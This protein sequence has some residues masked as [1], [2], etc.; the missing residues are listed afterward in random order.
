MVDYPKD[1]LAERAVLGSLMVAPRELF[2]VA[3]SY[4]L[5]E[6]DFFFREHRE[7]YRVVREL[8][9]EL[10][11]QWDDV[12]LFERIQKHGINLSR[13]YVLRIAEEGNAQEVLFVSA[14]K[15]IKELSIKRKLI[16]RVLV[17]FKDYEKKEI[18]DLAREVNLTL[19][20]LV[21]E[22][23]GGGVISSEA[24]EETIRRIKL[25]AH[26]E[27]VITGLPTGFMEL[28]LLTLGFHEGNYVVIG[29][30]P[31]M[32]KTSFMLCSA[33]AQAEQGHS[34]LI[35][36][37]EMSAPSLFERLLSVLS[38]VELSKIRSGFLNVEELDK[39]EKAGQKIKDL[40]LFIVDRPTLSVYELIV[41]ARQEKR[42]R[43]IKAIYVDYLQLLS[44][45]RRQN[46]YE[47]VSEVSRM[48]KSLAR[49]LKVPLI[50][51]AQLSR[52]VEERS[53]KRPQ[54]ADLRESGQIEQDADL[55]IFIHRPEYYKKSPPPEEQGIA[56]I[57]VAKQR[58]GPT[59]IIKLQFDKPT[60]AF[61]EMQK[62]VMPEEEK[63]E[64]LDI[65]F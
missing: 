46:R 51:L 18:Q 49:D 32:G 4:S 9:L 21:K 13:E 25:R 26:S 6:E 20:L 34:V 55:I 60:T 53:D 62:E 65:E 64:D 42:K 41:L 19:D 57:I 44:A 16:D 2:P 33:L 63:E 31:S 47:E 15:L 3:L 1:E 17:L 61:R 59:G 58:Q 27:K 52:Q 39:I 50:A 43:D 10:E 22:E 48:L 30:R 23:K 45:S 54:L 7:L 40:G 12:V 24:V 29:A 5:D 11:D 38:G 35:F 56:E 28:D 36:S 37:L 8:Y 14:L